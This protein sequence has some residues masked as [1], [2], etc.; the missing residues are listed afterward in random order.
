LDELQSAF[1]RSKLPLLDSDNAHRTN[2]AAR[3]SEGL[4]GLNGLILPEVYAD[5][6]HLWHLYVVRHPNRD[7]LQ[8]H[9]AELDVGTMIHYPIPPHLQS[10]YKDLALPEG[11]LPISEKIHREVLSLPMGPTLSLK[12]TDVIIEAVHKALGEIQ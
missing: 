2:I 4:R 12:D 9:L 3:Y 5:C 6:D 10:A 1:L 11:S 8:K 7:A